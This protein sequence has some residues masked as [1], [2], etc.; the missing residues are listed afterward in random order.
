MCFPVNIAKFLRSLIKKNICKRQEFNQT[1]NPLISGL[2][3][4]VT[5]GPATEISQNSLGNTCVRISFLI[6]LQV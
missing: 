5:P 6:K 2:H 4:V 1:F 3:K